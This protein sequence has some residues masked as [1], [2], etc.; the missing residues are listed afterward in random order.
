M[1]HISHQDWEPV[2]I[3][4]T[5]PV[6]G[7]KPKKKKYIASEET[8]LENQFDN[9]TFELPKSNITLQKAIQQGRLKEKLSQADLAKK[10]NMK[11]SDINN[12]ENGK[13]V[14]PNRIIARL[15]TILK[16]KLPRIKK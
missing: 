1:S 14:P 6:I 15:E 5:N 11:A 3:K 7:G 4:S 12:F 13:Q 10:L 9:D 2:Q 8:K 16:T